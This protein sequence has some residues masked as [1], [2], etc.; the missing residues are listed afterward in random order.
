MRR[1]FGTIG[2]TYLTVLT[3]AFYCNHPVAWA[4][5]AAL[6]AIAVTAGVLLQINKKRVGCS[7][8]V[9]GVTALLAVLSIFLYENIQYQPVVDTYSDKE[10]SFRGYIADDLIFYDS[11][12]QIPLITEEVDGKPVRLNIHLT[13]YH[14]EELAPFDVVEGQLH[15]IAHD[16]AN[17]ISKGCFLSAY[18]DEA[19]QLSATGERRSLPY[20]TVVWARQKIKNQIDK[21]LSSDS[22]SLCKAIL[23]GDKYA[24]RP[25]FK[26]DF[27]RT[28]TSFLIVVSGMHLSVICGFLLFLLRGARVPRLPAT[29]VIV[30]TVIIFVALSGFTRSVIRAAVMIVLSLSDR[31]FFRRNDSL[32]ALGIAGLVLSVCNPFV[33]GDFG[34]IMSFTTTAG[35]VLW[36]PTIIEKLTAWLHISCIR[37][38][39]LRWF[40]NFFI[41]LLA[42]SVCAALWSYPVSALFLGEIS[43]LVILVSLLTSP[44]ACLI[45]IGVLIMLI[46]SVIPFLTVPLSAVVWVMEFLC[47]LHLQLNTFFADWRFAKFSV[48]TALAVWLAAS[49]LLVSIGYLIWAKRRYIVFSVMLSAVILTAGLAVEALTKED[50]TTVLLDRDYK[51]L[52]VSVCHNGRMSF[53]S[54]GGARHFDGTILD[55]LFQYGD[56]ADYLFIPNSVNYSSYSEMLIK[57]FHPQS[58][59][60]TEVTASELSLSGCTCPADHSETVYALDDHIQDRI[61]ME[62]NILY[63]YLTVDETTILFLPHNADVKKLPE[64]YRTADVIIMDFYSSNAELLCCGTLIYTGPEN[65]RYQKNHDTLEAI[66]EEI[67]PVY[68]DSFRLTIQKK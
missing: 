56:G 52:T 20:Q 66:S 50:E 32:N 3:A 60:T 44:I 59:I 22:A 53:L 49:C 1:L 16:N 5:M 9:S 30:I 65:Q 27:Q 4:A 31:L 68:K 2:L 62:N 37:F 54:C 7:V 58:V 41:N 61:I 35:I 23:F 13:V 42:V 26:H 55:N 29:I 36:A 15:T 40:P 6:G 12:V 10:I 28:G 57:H 34:L 33:V 39:L 19:F 11:A 21:L 24:L 67:I 47:S 51:G 43:P 38:R 25:E 64:T 8:L 48:N 17:L 18:Q 46:V 14:T 45:L 63:Q